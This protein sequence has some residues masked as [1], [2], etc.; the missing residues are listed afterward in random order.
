MDH[1]SKGLEASDGAVCPPLCAW[2]GQGGGDV[3]PGSGSTS[4]LMGR[5]STAG[6]HPGECVVGNPEMSLQAA[7]VLRYRAGSGGRGTA[8]LLWEPAGGAGLG[9][10]CRSQAH[11]GEALTAG[12]KHGPLPLRLPTA[13]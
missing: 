4:T 1:F 8:N 10:L 12:C 7:R 2:L 13:R 6:E 5:V 9:E 11:G 3:P